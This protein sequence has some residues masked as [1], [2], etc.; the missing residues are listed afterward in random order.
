MPLVV[1]MVESGQ[2]QPTPGP[3]FIRVTIHLNMPETKTT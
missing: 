3:S 1:P 2:P